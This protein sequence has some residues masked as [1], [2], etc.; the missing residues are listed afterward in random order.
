M[1]ARTISGRLRE[2]LTGR[3][4]TAGTR[5]A[6]TVPKAGTKAKQAQE[7][8]GTAEPEP[9]PEEKVGGKGQ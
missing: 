1:I 6:E 8:A 5:K 7:K 4:E 2:A 3:P 9:K